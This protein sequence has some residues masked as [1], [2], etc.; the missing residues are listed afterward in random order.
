MVAHGNRLVALGELFD[1]A[2]ERRDADAPTLM[3]EGDL[4]GV[5][6][7]GW[8]MAEGVLAVRGRRRRLRGLR[9]ERRAS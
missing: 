1:V 7:I 2:V 9:H 8:Q 5:D 4:R 3:L 6:R